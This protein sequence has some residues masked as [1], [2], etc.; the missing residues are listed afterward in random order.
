MNLP[1]HPYIESTTV[2]S[3]C[4]QCNSQLTQG[5]ENDFFAR[6]YGQSGGKWL[7]DVKEFTK[8]GTVLLCHEHMEN[9][10][11]STLIQTLR[12]NAVVVIV[13]ALPSVTD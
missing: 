11:C 8:R 1:T 6:I 2:L 3:G 7:P 13:V 12:D 10:Q 9:V 5:G 4:L